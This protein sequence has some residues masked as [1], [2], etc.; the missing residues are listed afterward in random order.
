M[1]TEEGIAKRQADREE[2]GDIFMNSE[3][4]NE[5]SEGMIL[6]RRIYLMFL[7]ITF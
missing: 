1:D 2:F 3:D 4:E 5:P 7:L 6:E